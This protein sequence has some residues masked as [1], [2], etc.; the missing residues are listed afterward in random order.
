MPEN[1]GTRPQ[2]AEWVGAAKLLLNGM[3]ERRQ[4]RRQ[5]AGW[6]NAVKVLLKPE[7]VERLSDSQVSI[8]LPPCPDFDIDEDV[9][10]DV[11]IPAEV[12]VI[13]DRP[14]YAGSFTIKADTYEERIDSAIQGLREERDG[15]EPGAAVASFLLTFFT[16][17]IVAK[18]VVSH[19][20]Y[21]GSG[22]KSPV[23]KYTTKDVGG[24]LKDLKVD[25]NERLVDQLFSTE[26]QA[27]ASEMSARKLR[28]N[29]V[30]RMKP[31][32][33]SAVRTRYES[34]METMTQ[35]LTAIEAWRARSRADQGSRR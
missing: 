1:R 23:T 17:E 2:P 35:F 16:C 34:L 15:P 11:W 3:H 18:S 20:K 33:R 25:F 8:T 30:H 29:V 10:V 21:K 14:L 19:S 24:A 12:L 26:E 4:G 6:D 22:R 31:N 27:L 32:H 28:D 7:H 13:S 5:S 9:T